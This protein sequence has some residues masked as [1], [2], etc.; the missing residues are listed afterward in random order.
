MI[1]AKEVAKLRGRS[2]CYIPPK[3][4]HIADRIQRSWLMA[5]MD[6]GSIESMPEICI[7]EAYII[8]KV[9]LIGVMLLCLLL[10]T[11]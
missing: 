11:W 3:T 5:N 2:R 8:K 9:A 1:F 4:G 7:L 10:V 6:K